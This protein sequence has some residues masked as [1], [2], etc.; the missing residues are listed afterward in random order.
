[1]SFIYSPPPLFCFD[2][3]PY[4]LILHD[5]HKSF[6][7]IT[8]VYDECSNIDASKQLKY[9]VFKG[10]TDFFCS[11]KVFDCYG[12]KK[13]QYSDPIFEAFLDPIFVAFV[14]DNATM[15][16]IRHF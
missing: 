3:N 14:K 4:R 8:T 5:Q 2:K 13:F 12:Y 15:S 6:F 11:L 9:L 16:S 1:M 10:F 7:G